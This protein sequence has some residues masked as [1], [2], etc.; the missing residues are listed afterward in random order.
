MKRKASRAWKRPLAGLLTL[1]MVLS[2][3]STSPLSASATE[4][5]QTVTA[6][7]P[8]EQEPEKTEQ[9]K[10][11]IDA[12]D[13]ADETEEEEKSEDE[14]Q[15]EEEKSTDEK[16]PE[17]EELQTDEDKQ[18]E[19]ESL[20]EEERK[21][22]EKE[23]NQETEKSRIAKLQKGKKA[24]TETSETISSNVQKFL[25]AV[26][27]FESLENT[28]EISNTDLSEL[29]AVA[30]DAYETL[31]EEE[32]E[33]EDVQRAMAIM[34]QAIDSLTGGI[35]P[36]SVQRRYVTLRPTDAEGGTFGAVKVQQNDWVSSYN[37]S[38]RY[39]VRSV[40]GNEITVWVYL[41]NNGQFFFPKASDLWE[42]V[43][44]VAYVYWT[45]NSSGKKTENGSGLTSNGAPD[46]SCG[47]ATYYF[48]KSG[49]TGDYAWNFELRFDAN[50]GTGAPNTLTY[51]TNSQYERSHTFNIPSQIP[52]REGYTFWGWAD[53]ADASEATRQPGGSCLVSYYADD[54][55]GSLISKTL[56][57]VWQDNTSTTPAKPT[58][59]QVMDLFTEGVV[60]VDCTNTLVSHANKTYTLL[61][62][63]FCIGEV[64]G[65]S[66]SG[67]TCT[68]TVSPEKYVE[69]YSVDMSASHTLS[70]EN[71]SGK[72]I[73]LKYQNN[74]WTVTAGAV[75]TYT[76]VCDNTPTIPDTDWTD[77]TIDKTVN[78]ET[79]KPGDTI[80]Y[81][82]TVS[83]NTG[84]DLKNITVS[85][86]LNFNLEFVSAVPV[87][88]YN[89]ETGIWTI[90]SLGSGADAVLT[91]T[92][93]VKEEV[94]SDTTINNTATITGA[95]TNDGEELP[96]GTNPED[97]VDITVD[98]DETPEEETGRVVLSIYRDGNTE[99]PVVKDAVIGRYPLGTDMRDIAANIDLDEYYTEN[100]SASG[101]E[102][103]EKWYK[104]GSVLKW[105]LDESSV[106]Q[107][108]DWNRIT[109]MVYDQYAVNYH[110][111]GEET[112]TE[113]ITARNIEDYELWQPGDK[114][115]HTF[116]G[117]YEDK[118]DIGNEAKR[119]P[120]P[121]AVLK[122]YELYGKYVAKE[123]PVYVYIYRDGNTE[124]AA[125]ER[126]LGDFAYGTPYSEILKDAVIDGKN[127]DLTTKDG[128]DVLYDPAKFAADFEWD[129]PWSQEVS[130]LGTDMTDRT[131]NGWTNLCTMVYDRYAVNYHIE[132]EETHTEYITARNI[133]DYKLWQPG[134]KEG[135]TFDGWYEKESDIGNEAKREPEPLTVLKKYE[136]YGEYVAKEYPVYIYIYRD[137]NTEEAAI[138]RKLGDYAYGTPYSEILK[139]A[140]IDGKNSDLTTKDGID[141]LYDPAK[142]AADFEW[143]IPWSQEVSNLGTDMTDRT[144]NGW[145]NLCTMV[146]DRY[147]VN[148]HIDDE[149]TITE[150]ITART[151]G[152]YKLLKA[153]EREGY[154]FDG[155]YEKKSDI[156]NEAKREPEPLTVLKKYE[157]YGTYA[158][159]TY[160]IEYHGNG[161]FLTRNP[162]KDVTTST[163]TYGVEAVLKNAG[164]FTREGYTFLGWAMNPDDR[165]IQFEGSQK[166]MNLASGQGSV[167]RLYA[168]WASNASILDPVS[169]A[170]KVEH[171]LEN[172][173]GTYSLKD[174]DFPLY[175]EV[176]TE[177]TA[178]AGDYEHYTLNPEHEDYQASGIVTVPQLG[179]DAQ[180]PTVLTLKL[181]YNLDR[182]TVTFKSDDRGI[183]DGTEVEITGTYK[184]GEVYPTAPAVTAVD[185]YVFDGWY[186]G[187]QKISEFPD[188][189]TADAVYE[190]GYKED[191][192]HNGIAD[193]AETKYTV[194]YTDGVD[195]EELF[196]DQVYENLLSGTS[197][198]AFTG[199][200]FR[201]GYVFKGWEPAVS[202]TVTGNA[203]YKAVWEKNENGSGNSG[204]SGNSSGSGS[205]SSSG[206]SAASSNT[207]AS[208]KTG[209]TSPILLLTLTG[210]VSLAGIGAIVFDR[211][212]KGYHGRDRH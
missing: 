80:S 158:A 211:R 51:G 163:H 85:E 37:G 52:I 203:V 28:E 97:K 60:T 15:P 206:T 122:K 90:P 19:E 76:V 198:P 129:I 187:G 87:N 16:Q 50:G 185:G 174:V 4:P 58:E 47:L 189:V 127:S 188:M 66:E 166:V 23:E 46:S 57:A 48:E 121:L 21:D 124:E 190:A 168:L 165:T 3:L 22:S 172:T 139:D 26:D 13:P 150:Y 192:N 77:L 107:K 24:Q 126:K 30:L 62:D 53:D 210:L 88:Q 71:Q 14:K 116:D 119:E 183:L 115:G 67:Y 99:E 106:V 181:Y 20:T 151:I 104:D 74:S 148:Y 83:N 117:W 61:E 91:I 29:T 27:A 44:D 199:T 180:E 63:S 73:T 33:R 42:N 209:D 142:F 7:D 64:E 131:V 78:K 12:Q 176:G 161:G 146:Y 25:D 34:Q 196:K 152:D 173:D 1:V 182:H 9:T 167:V 179:A 155:W 136:L 6:V 96:D 169:A 68:I 75:I 134:E 195:G 113:Y 164:T 191:K 5:E 194:T 110:I 171:Y 205:G 202:P 114:D 35:K 162:E 17:E 140:V 39:Q 145:T 84:K 59:E 112:H 55:S 132:G 43:S 92:A 208:P 143:D 41:D 65:D 156:G 36:L 144:V 130:N 95:E 11:D 123:Y 54:V 177:V 109:C 201:D 86:K 56:Y 135:H 105:E 108:S 141:V 8:E 18:K 133:E 100:K 103:D 70:P 212:K 101:Y 184:Y 93:T 2:L 204:G 138:E 40:N 149:E 98:N 178:E 153:E 128:I 69:K 125:V 89:S 94:E 160:T 207:V 159:H 170:Y 154:T 79:A 32:L 45:G 147:A 200:L 137:G 31:S 157:L 118:D 38:N 193:D 81:T 102:F 72:K 49:G 111:E 82:I 186:A 120:E 175:G 197:T 10:K